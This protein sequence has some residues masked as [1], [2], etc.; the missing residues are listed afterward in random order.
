M[1]VDERPVAKSLLLRCSLVFFNFFYFSLALQT[2][3]LP[4]VRIEEEDPRDDISIDDDRESVD[5]LAT[6]MDE[7]C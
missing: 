2:Q 6:A 7:E 3:P 4:Q 1:D 5:L